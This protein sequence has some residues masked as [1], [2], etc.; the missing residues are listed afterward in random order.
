MWSATRAAPLAPTRIVWWSTSSTRSTA[1]PALVQSGRVQLLFA[2]EP[3][4][5]VHDA[6]LGQQQ[7]RRAGK[8]MHSPRC[9]SIEEGVGRIGPNGGERARRAQF[10]RAAHEVA[11]HVRL[12]GAGPVLHHGR[13]A[14]EEVQV[15][16][17]AGEGHL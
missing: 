16:V 8:L 14:A 15:R 13:V 7:P 2:V 5:L 12:D 11:Q 9:L 4:R 3:L 17:A 10:R 1:T 6:A